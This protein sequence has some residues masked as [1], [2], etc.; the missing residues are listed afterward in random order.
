MDSP[1][2]VVPSEDIKVEVDSPVPGTVSASRAIPVPDVDAVRDVVVDE[3][4]A[5]GAIP[6]YYPHEY[7]PPKKKKKTWLIILI[8]SVVLVAG[9]AVAAYF[10]DPFGWFGSE[11][12]SSSSV[13]D[14]SDSNVNEDK[15]ATSDID[16]DTT[17]EEDKKADKKK[18]IDD[19]TTDKDTADSEKKEKDSV[20]ETDSNQADVNSDD[21]QISD[22]IS[23]INE[24]IEDDDF[25][26]FLSLTILEVTNVDEDEHNKSINTIEDLFNKYVD[27][28]YEFVFMES[29]TIDMS[30]GDI[31]RIN[32]KLK[33]GHELTDTR[34]F[35]YISIPVDDEVSDADTYKNYAFTFQ[36]I[37]VD[38][39][40]C[41]MD[42]MPPLIPK[43]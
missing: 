20:D 23:K 43:E 5:Y 8:I 33:S 15:E 30:E 37:Q 12:A 2:P 35:Q 10:I 36:F 19:K 6:G 22:V 38:D 4:S 31:S 25:D 16:E 28:G 26:A 27:S 3:S 41:I 13:E 24:A 21:G 11:P 7:E 34:M 14:I 1:A 29:K 40:W 17:D 32:E 18:D 39:E 9:L 42:L